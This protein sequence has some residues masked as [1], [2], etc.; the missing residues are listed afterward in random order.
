R[1]RSLSSAGPRGSL[2]SALVRTCPLIVPPHHGRL[3][4][5]TKRTR[6]E[7]TGTQGAGIPSMIS[8]DGAS[9][10]LIALN[11]NAEKLPAI[12]FPPSVVLTLS[13]RPRF[14]LRAPVE[15]APLVPTLV[16]AV[17]R[18]LFEKPWCFPPLGVFLDPLPGNLVLP[19]EVFGIRDDAV[20]V[21]ER[22]LALD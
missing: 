20:K 1:D 16:E 7:A 9:I 18:P 17:H 5:P 8:I 10:T 12:L 4:P 14:P 21:E 19:F 15:N 6:G 13:G 22:L 3:R 11:F 2:D